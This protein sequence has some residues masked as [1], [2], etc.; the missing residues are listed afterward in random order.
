MAGFRR[1]CPPHQRGGAR[2][3][4]GAA[5]GRVERVE[6]GVD[7]WSKMEQVPTDF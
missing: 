5:R 4:G 7:L 1:L 2:G 3:D 6:G